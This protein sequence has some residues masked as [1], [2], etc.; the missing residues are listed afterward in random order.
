MSVILIDDLKGYTRLLNG[1]QMFRLAEMEYIQRGIEFAEERAKQLFTL[2]C[3]N[4]K[5]WNIRY[6]DDPAEQIYTEDQFI[7]RQL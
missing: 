7:N 3:L 6:K 4:V 5:S 2:H 1:I